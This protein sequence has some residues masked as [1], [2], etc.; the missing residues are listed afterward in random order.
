MDYESI[1]KLKTQYL[2]H[3]HLALQKPDFP[4]LQTCFISFPPEAKKKDENKG[5]LVINESL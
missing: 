2:Q 3:T 1:Q 5:G 4:G